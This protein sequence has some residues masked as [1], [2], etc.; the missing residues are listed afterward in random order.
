[1]I[2]AIRAE[3]RKL[4]TVRWTYIVILLCLLITFLIAF[5]AAGYKQTHNVTDPSALAGIP[6]GVV[7]ALAFLVSLVGVLLLTHE[8][9][10]NTIL[11]TLTSSASRTYVLIA[12]IV[13]ISVF[14]ILLTLLLCSLAPWLTSLGLHAKGLTLSPQDLPIR[15][16]L[17]RCVL[18]GWGYSMLALII[19]TIVR[20]QVGV[21]A[22]LFLV[23]GLGEMLLGLLL[24]ENAKYLPFGTLNA[25]VQTNAQNYPNALIVLLAY[26]AG[27]WLIAWALF[28]RRDAN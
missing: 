18:Y 26:I 5:Y 3:F 24:K 22:I 20:N 9:R 17:V 27:G 19:A 16:L 13:V 23:P 14:A 15:D 4:L 2:P 21:I 6:T 25:V 10:Y 28:V 8:Y 7:Q 11:Y 12:K 1:M